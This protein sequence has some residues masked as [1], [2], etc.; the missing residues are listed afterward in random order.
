MK[1]NIFIFKNVNSLR[2]HEWVNG[3]QARI[4]HGQDVFDADF[5]E[6]FLI[7]IAFYNK[8]TKLS[9]LQGFLENVLLDCIDANQSI[10][11][12]CLCLSNTMTSILSL[13]V[14]C[15]IP[16][17]IVEYDAVSTGQVDA[18]AATSCRWDE[19]KDFSIVIESVN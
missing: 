8:T 2:L 11:M 13:F 9:F 15:W 1:H 17:C 10:D 6:K 4:L 14:H 5:L 3:S 7:E 19:A 18:H 12:N 16:I